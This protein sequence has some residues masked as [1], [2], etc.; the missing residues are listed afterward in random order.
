[1]KAIKFLESASQ[2]IYNSYI[3]RVKRVTKS[4]SAVD[5]DEILLEI[6]SHIYEGIQQKKDNNEID[7]LLDV[8]ER[9]G[10]PEVV[11][12]PLV[13]DKKLTEATKT[14]NPIHIFKAL[15]LNLKNGF[16]YFIFSIL[17]LSLF[18]FIYAVIIKII[19]PKEVGLFIG[20]GTVETL[21]TYKSTDPNDGVNEVLGNWFIPVMLICA[22]LLFIIITFLLK[23]KHH[24]KK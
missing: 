6:N 23:L 9:L 12:K 18:G 8:I 19:N 22:I 24:Q 1:M 13:A 5:R 16:I 15:I 21:G 3:Q 7:S 14:L 4:L 17:Y 11:L 10:E 2:K 20:N